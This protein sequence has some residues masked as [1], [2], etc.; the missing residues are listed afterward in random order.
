M[1]K[2]R[3]RAECT[4]CLLLLVAGL[5]LQ[6]R[7]LLADIQI[8]VERVWATDGQGAE[9]REF[10]PGEAIQYR[11]QLRMLTVAAVPLSVRLR[12]LGD[13]WYETHEKKALFGP[14]FHEVR[15]GGVPSLHTSPEACEGKVA[16]HLDVEGQET[17]FTENIDLSGSRHAFFS[18]SCEAGGF[19]KRLV[20]HVRVGQSPFDMAL[21]ADGR[22]LYVTNRES[23]SISVLETEEPF[24]VVAQIESPGVIVEPT[25][26]AL[27]ANGTEML[28]ADHATQKIHI[29]DTAAHRLE[30]SVDILGDFGRVGMGDLVLDPVRNELY[31]CDL[32]D[33]RVLAI[34]GQS[35]AARSILLTGTTPSGWVAGLTPVKLL[36]DPQRFLYVLATALGELIQVDPIQGAVVDSYNKVN[37]PASSMTFNPDHTRLYV[38][39]TGVPGVEGI[40]QEIP[41]I[42]YMLETQEL[43]PEASFHLSAAL[44]DLVVRQDGRFAYVVNSSRGEL[45]VVDLQGGYELRACAVPVGYGG[46]I[47]LADPRRARVYI[48]ADP[49][50]LEIVE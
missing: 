44:W 23:G 33:S 50:A 4:A 15:W 21:T 1:Q 48:G 46:H 25:G 26:A 7:V 8:Q 40:Y 36:L 19:L 18:V 12:V 49:G 16:L 47:L 37:V 35:F 17:S 20:G 39:R 6:P 9:K 3:R 45:A 30:R 24:E 28:V 5:L 41:S 11:A 32:A 38:L 31:A 22:Y 34:D 14:G 2:A 27:A 29:L 10:L 42:L 13:G 43:S